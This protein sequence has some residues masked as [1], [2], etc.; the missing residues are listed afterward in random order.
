[1]AYGASEF[2]LAYS[3]SVLEH[4]PGT[5]DSE[6]ILEIG[7]VLRPGGAVCVT[8]PF[9]PA[10]YREEWVRGDVY[11]RKFRDEAVF[12]Q[13]H[14]DLESL[15]RRLVEP[16]GMRLER[17]EHFGEPGLQFERHWNRIPMMWKL[18]LLWA[19]AFL[20]HFLFKRLPPDRIDRATGVALLLR[21]PH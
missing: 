17:L 3:V 12:D 15:N 19:Q 14:Y 10:G 2:D 4:I 6:A 7:R 5:G 21:K 8:V 11:E 16:S 20:A 13:R 18:P 1:M 9:D